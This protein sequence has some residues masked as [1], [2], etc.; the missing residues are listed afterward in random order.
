MATIEVAAAATQKK[1]CHKCS[2][3]VNESCKLCGFQMCYRCW[4]QR[5][6]PGT[7]ERCPWIA[8]KFIFDNPKV[9]NG[10]HDVCDQCYM[11][12]YRSGDD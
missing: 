12:P 5:H 9:K 3:E 6:F 7:T 1:T 4:P 8:R 11:A 2:S 10:W